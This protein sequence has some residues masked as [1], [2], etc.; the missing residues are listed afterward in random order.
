MSLIPWLGKQDGNGTGRT[1]MTELRNEMNRLFDNF[2]R[3]PFGAIGDSFA[4]W[5]QVM[6]P[7]EISETENEVTVKAE[8][9]GVDP[10]DLDLTV[11]GDRLTIS[12]EKRESKETKEDSYRQRETR[13]GRF[14]RSLQLPAG[15][16]PQQVTAEHANGVLTV[17]I[18][19]SPQ[20]A[21]KKIPIS[22]S[23]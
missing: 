17:R 22:T 7:V 3:E 13:Y 16:D 21:A 10:K 5:G 8:I 19:K 4:A 14:S 23:R 6:P 12:G 11:N 2:I 18:R 9:A 20:A 1:T 15:V